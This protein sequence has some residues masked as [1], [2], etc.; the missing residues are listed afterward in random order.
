MNEVTSEVQRT[1]SNIHAVARHLL[2]VE[3][4]D[5]QLYVGV[6]PSGVS[7]KVVVSYQGFRTVKSAAK[8]GDALDQML[9]DLTSRV[10]RKL[11]EGMRIV[12]MM[13]DVPTSP[14]AVIEDAVLGVEAVQAVNVVSHELGITI[15]TV[16]P[17]GV[18][19][20][21]ERD[22]MCAAVGAALERVR[23]AGSRFEVRVIGLVVE[24][25]FR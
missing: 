13:R 20:L 19:K 11:D 16:T 23:A 8:L 3:S 10:S 14:I 7:W 1:L 6:T 25:P 24:A 5:E 4:E 12:A 9:Q 18:Q 22:A 15:V 17:H 21:E 2:N